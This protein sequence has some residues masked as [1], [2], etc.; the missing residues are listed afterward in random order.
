MALRRARQ[1]QLLQRLQRQLER[2]ARAAAGPVRARQ[3]ARQAG[4]DHR[5]EQH[6]QPGDVHPDQQDG[7]RGEGAVH[8]RIGRH[9][10][11]VEGEQP[12]GRLDAHRGEQAAHDRVLAPHRRVRHVPVQRAQRA[13][14]QQEL[15]R[16]DQELDR[17]RQARHQPARRGRHVGGGA[18]AQRQQQRP[19]RDRRPV[20]QHPLGQRPRAA[21][22]PDR[23]ERAVDREHQRQRAH[24]QRTEADGAEPAGAAGELRDVIEHLPRDGVRHQALHQPG[25]QVRLQ[26]AEDGKGGEERQGHREERHQRDHG[27]EG[28]AAGRQPQPVLAKARAQGPQGRPPGKADEVFEQRAPIHRPV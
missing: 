22:A 12:L 2:P 25:L 28:Q 4:G 26:L 14:Q 1:M 11:Q 27:G 8:H 17:A 18:Q 6:H 9:L 7:Q 15:Q 23:I 21:H 19:E 5:A 3:Q 24:H 10:V 13:H 20:H 16:V